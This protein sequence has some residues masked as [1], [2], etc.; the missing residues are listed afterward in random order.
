MLYASH[1]SAF[2]HPW[3][4]NDGFGSVVAGLRET[5]WLGEVEKS[6]SFEHFGRIRKRNLNTHEKH[7]DTC[8][9]GA[10]DSLV[11]RF[12]LN[13]DWFFELPDSVSSDGGSTSESDSDEFDCGALMDRNDPRDQWF[14]TSSSVTTPLW[15]QGPNLN[16][17]NRW[18]EHSQNS[19]GQTDHHD[20]WWRA[21][22]FPPQ[23]MFSRC[24][25]WLRFFGRLRREAARF[26]DGASKDTGASSKSKLVGKRFLALA[27]VRHEKSSPLSPAQ[28][29]MQSDAKGQENPSQASGDRLHSQVSKHRKTSRIRFNRPM[30]VA[31]RIQAR[32]RVTDC[33]CQVLEESRSLRTR[34]VRFGIWFV[35]CQRENSIMHRSI[36]V[37]WTQAP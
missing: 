21:W 22:V 4:E 28:E 30:S 2:I 26:T 34:S 1:L 23:P 31:T 3:Y 29:K 18:W 32:H 37:I 27:T 10:R 11:H 13:K 35:G 9:V 14:Q 17:Q 19:W 24:H 8:N 33:I 20:S 15:A 36:V 7:T 16:W 12:E 5:W 6:E 25:F